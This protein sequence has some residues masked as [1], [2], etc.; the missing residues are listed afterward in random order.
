MG[1]AVVAKRV[2]IVLRLP[3]AETHG[4]DGETGDVSIWDGD[5]EYEDGLIP[6]LSPDHSLS[7]SASQSHRRSGDSHPNLYDA[8]T[9]EIGKQRRP[10]ADIFG[11]K[12]GGT[13]SYENHAWH[14]ELATE[15]SFEHELGDI[16]TSST[17]TTG[18]SSSAIS[19]FPDSPT[20]NKGTFGKRTLPEYAWG[21]KADHGHSINASKTSKTVL[22][23]ML[24]EFGLEMGWWVTAHDHR[25]LRTRL[26]IGSS[27]ADE[28]RLSRRSSSVRFVY[29][30]ATL[31]PRAPLPLRDREDGPQC[32][33]PAG[34]A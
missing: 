4:G 20:T 15:P 34:Q 12:G 2:G 30:A 17:L 27:E 8:T 31:R 29:P 5:E 11:S 18:S 14:G 33:H 23:E 3:E 21:K 32:R 1:L 28:I 7:E 25:K 22:Q 10:D 6:P 9:K 19:A 13:V 26:C 16:T 24:E